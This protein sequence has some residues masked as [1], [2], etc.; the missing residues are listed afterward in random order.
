MEVRGAVSIERKRLGGCASMTTTT[1]A[2]NVPVGELSWGTTTCWVWESGLAHGFSGSS[3][4]S[5]P[6]QTD[7]CCLKITSYKQGLSK[8]TP[9]Y[10]GGS[11]SVYFSIV[12]WCRIPSLAPWLLWSMLFT[13]LNVKSSPVLLRWANMH[14]LDCSVKCSISATYR[15]VA[16]KVH[17]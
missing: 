8:P 11:F 10:V 4:R 12:Y 5:F 14:Y 2:G 16:P 6:V 3:W 1:M 7:G 15:T 9:L 13:N 17:V